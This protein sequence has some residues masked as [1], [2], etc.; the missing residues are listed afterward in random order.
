WERSQTLM[1]ITKNDRIEVGH[2]FPGYVTGIILKST[3]QIYLRS[4]VVKGGHMNKP[5]SKRSRA[6]LPHLAVVLGITALIFPIAAGW[7]WGEGWLAQR[8]FYDFAGSV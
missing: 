1:M 2:P 3:V 5:T 8:G 4:E 6:P 7:V